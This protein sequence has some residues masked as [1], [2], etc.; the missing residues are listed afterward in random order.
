MINTA[1]HIA[2]MRIY[3]IHK[4]NPDN[5][6][7]ITIPMEWRVLLKPKSVANIL[8]T[9]QCLII[10]PAY[11]HQWDPDSIVHKH[12]IDNTGR[13]LIGDKLLNAFDIKMI[14]QVSLI[15]K[16]NHIELY[17]DQSK[18]KEA[19]SRAMQAAMEFQA[20]LIGNLN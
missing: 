18:V 20:K 17:W 10:I 5:K 16:W 7:R 1:E 9:W 12:T 4:V 2:E 15:G 11:L 8:Y 3:G 14:N 19:V 13:I 6:K